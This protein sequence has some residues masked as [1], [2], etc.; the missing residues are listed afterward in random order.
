MKMFLRKTGQQVYPMPWVAET[1]RPWKSGYHRVYLPV[2]KH[3]NGLIGHI[4]IVK[5]SN[6]RTEK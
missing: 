5:D 3:K 4:L 1:P 6:L 2:G